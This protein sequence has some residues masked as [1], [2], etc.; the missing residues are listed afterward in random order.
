[1]RDMRVGDEEDFLRSSGTQETQL[2]Q[3]GLLLLIM[4]HL[5]DG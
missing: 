4:F 2:R 3:R 1:M 5:K